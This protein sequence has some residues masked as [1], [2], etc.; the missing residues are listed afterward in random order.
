L[1]PRSDPAGPPDGPGRVPFTASHLSE[2]I[3]MPGS[4]SRRLEIEYVISTQQAD[5]AADGFNQRQQAREKKALT[6]AEAA[7]IAKQKIIEK[8]NQAKIAAA[9]KAQ[10]AEQRAGKAGVEAAEKTK[11]AIM[12]GVAAVGKFG[13]AMLGLQGAQQIVSV[14]GDTFAKIRQNAFEAAKSVQQ[15][16]GD[17]RELQALRNQMGQTGPG[18]SHVF[19]IARQTLQSPEQVQQMEQAGLGVGELALK[20]A[21][22]RE[23]FTKAIVA[24]GRFQ[25]IEGGDAG[26][27][28]Q[29][30]GQ[31]ALQSKGPINAADMEARAYK[32][33]QIQQPGGFR[34]MSQA[35]GQYSKLNALVQNGIYTPEEAMS[36][37]SAF[38]V[39]SPEEAATRTEQFTRAVMS[40]RIKS[41][42][43]QVSS[44]VDFEKTD[45]YFK[46]IGIG[47]NDTAIARGKK[48]AEDLARQQAAN[49]NFNAYE[50]LMTRGFGNAEDREAIM[51]LSGLRN[52]GRLE[53]IESAAKAPLER[54]AI[55][56]RFNERLQKDNFLKG[57]QLEL[58]EQ[59]ATIN[60]G[61]Q[62][63]PLVLAQHAAFNRL[64]AQ[65]KITGSFDDWQRIERSGLSGSAEAGVKDMFLSNYHS[66]VTREMM[67]GLEGERRRLGVPRMLPGLTES[68]HDY[69]LRF[70]RGVQERGGDVTSGAADALNKAAANVERATS[71]LEKQMN[72]RNPVPQPMPGRPARQQVR[73]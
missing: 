3:A 66:Q 38:S 31:I 6:D 68:A 36:L 34:T 29:M 32:L 64:K 53:A 43:M 11:A 14:L 24:A 72:Q 25:A 47:E 26:A 56:K 18:V 22:D 49:K 1:T 39:S 54:G 35:M 40:G 46:G 67:H 48:I 52:T 37:A 13:A 60:E 51:A 12:D 15:M 42:G 28:G 9:M 4:G 7:E 23:E 17:V 45:E 10:E 71:A 44:D 65:G 16:R 55:A 5:A 21:K 30:M 20:N 8:T 61:L 73:P 19:D 58:G 62:E 41:R 59:A 27:Y 63:E 70:A 33:F 50:Y 69:E 57:R 2:A